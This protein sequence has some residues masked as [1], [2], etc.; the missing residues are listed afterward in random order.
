MTPRH[1]L[2]PSGQEVKDLHTENILTSPIMVGFVEIIAA[3]H[4][5]TRVNFSFE[6]S[7]S[8]PLPESQPKRE[9]GALTCAGEL[10]LL[11]I[12]QNV[13]IE[14]PTNSAAQCPTT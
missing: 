2:H 9:I 3:E 6:K 12:Y 7:S 14:D 13:P 8:L 10:N 5:G 11:S 4:K 1:Y